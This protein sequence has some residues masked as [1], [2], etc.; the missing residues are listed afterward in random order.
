MEN[1]AKKQLKEPV[2]AMLLRLTS[3]KTYIPLCGQGWIFCL[4]EAISARDLL[5]IRPG[6]IP[7]NH[8]K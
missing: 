8:E 4:F 3:R 2:N 6:N 7:K 1:K 5:Q